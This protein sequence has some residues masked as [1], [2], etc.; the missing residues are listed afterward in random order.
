MDVP[1]TL[2]RIRSVVENH[3]ISR[4]EYAC[5]FCHHAR[6]KQYVG[7]NPCIVRGQV[8]QRRDMFKR[9]NKNMDW[10]D[11][12]DIMKRNHMLVLVNQFGGNVAGCD[13]AENAVWVVT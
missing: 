11:R 13:L 5:F 2:E 10:R 7:G 12:I 9:N 4:I 6:G 3:P 8:A 1:Y